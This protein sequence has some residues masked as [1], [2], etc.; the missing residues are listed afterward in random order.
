MSGFVGTQPAV[1][2]A[3]HDIA[4]DTSLTVHH[5]LYPL[6][7]LGAPDVWDNDSQASDFLQSLHEGA[8]GYVSKESPVRRG[9]FFS[10]A[11]PSFRSVTSQLD[12][13]GDDGSVQLL[14]Y[15]TQSQIDTDKG[16]SGERWVMAILPC[17][18]VDTGSIHEGSLM[19]CHSIC[20]PDLIGALADVTEIKVSEN[21]ARKQA[22]AELGKQLSTHLSSHK[23]TRK[24]RSRSVTLRSEQVQSGLHIYSK[25]IMKYSV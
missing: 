12:C 16:R 15:R 10:T 8:F 11:V 14:I 3:Q 19:D 23:F 1:E 18:S 24:G 13:S 6:R 9:F 4:S 17:A 20:V 25:S 5:R 22:V 2:P 7:T 21:L